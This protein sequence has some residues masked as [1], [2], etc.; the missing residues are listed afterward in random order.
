MRWPNWLRKRTEK[1]VRTRPFDED[2]LPETAAPTLEQTVEEGMLLAEYATRMA[3]KNHI[4]VDTLQYGNDFDPARHT[5][6]A[7]H[8]LRELASEQGE[9]AGRIDADLEVA[10]GLRGDATHPHDYRDVDVANLR[11]RRDAAVALASALRAKA[12][13]EDEL[14]ALVERGRVDAWDE[15]GRAIEAG[16]DAFSGVEALKADYEREKPA[17]LKLLIWRDLARLQEERTGY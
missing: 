2:A 9:A 1:T 14:L 4:V 12:D 10:Q 8:L 15:V 16:L 17:R 7:A 11:L 13:S 6:E 3:V 5:G